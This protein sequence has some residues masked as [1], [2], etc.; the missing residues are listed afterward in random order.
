MSREFTDCQRI[1]RSLLTTYREK[2]WSPFTRAVRAYN[3]IEPGDR[4]AVCVSGGKDSMLMAKLFQELSRH[5]RVPFDA[6]YL[7]MDPGYSLRNRERIAATAAR[8]QIPLETFESRVFD[9]A[10]RQEKNP[11]YLCARMRR[12]HLYSRARELGCN[13]I[14]LGHHFNDVIETTLLGMFY[15]AQLQGMPPKIHSTNFPGMQLI[16]PLYLIHQDAIIAWKNLMA[17]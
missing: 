14:A 9:V 12:G 11:C 13:K 16:R 7:A 3:L 4:I 1:E 6:V 8:L 2:L 5:S 10:N 17:K 15:G